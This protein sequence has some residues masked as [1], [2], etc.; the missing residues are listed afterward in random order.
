MDIEE[1]TGKET[2]GRRNENATMDV[3]SYEAGQDQKGNN[4]RDNES[5]GNHNESTGKK[6]ELVWACEEK[7]GTLRRK[8]VMVMKVQ[9][10][11]KRGRTKRRWLVKVKDDIKEK[12]LPADHMYDR[13][14]CRGMSS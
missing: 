9:G 4:K 13:A 6:V 14:T 12:G 5:G 7:R 2:G 8:G 11:R 1:G 10:R 3:R